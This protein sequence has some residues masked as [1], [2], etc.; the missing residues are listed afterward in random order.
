MDI[1]ND[2][3]LDSPIDQPNPQRPK[4][5]HKIF[6]GL[7]LLLWGIVLFGLL[8][9]Y[10]SW[11]GGDEALI[12]S[13]AGLTFTYLLFPILLFDSRGWLRHVGSH[14][15]GLAMALAVMAFLFRAQHWEGAAE[16]ALLPFIPSLL[17]LLTVG[18]LILVKPVRWH[19]GH[20]YKHIMARMLLVAL[21]TYD[22]T[23]RIFFH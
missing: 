18:I 8:F 9:K 11:E 12:L 20:F 19:E 1:Q 10:E 2:T 15:A 16:M 13:A 7:E 4:L 21:L 22:E 14:V 6:F 17:I 23:F 5:A 3:P